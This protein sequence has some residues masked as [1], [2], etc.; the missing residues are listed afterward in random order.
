MPPPSPSSTSTRCPREGDKMTTTTVAPAGLTRWATQEELPAIDFA[1]L[2][3]GAPDAL[4]RLARQVHDACRDIGFFTVINHPVPPVPIRAVF[5]QSRRFFALPTEARM[6][7][8][9]GNGD[10]FRGY[11]PSDRGGEQRWPRGRAI[12]GFQLHL[13]EDKREE[14]KQRYNNQNDAFPINADLSA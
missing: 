2:R 10:S 14:R 1:P 4:D 12:P 5:E 11:L 9:M 3:G 7:H 8:Y 13:G 6:R